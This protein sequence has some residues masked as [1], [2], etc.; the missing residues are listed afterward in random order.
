[1]SIPGSEDDNATDRDVG[2]EAR[3]RGEWGR[4]DGRGGVGNGKRR[5]VGVELD[6]IPLCSVCSVEK[7]GENPGQV[8]ERGLEV[9]TSLDGGLSRDR[10]DILFDEREGEI[11]LSPKASTRNPRRLRGVTGIEQEL[12]RYINAS[13]GRYVSTN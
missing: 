5:G 1:M 6:T 4:W 12:K 13:S 10:L 9:V 2:L 7:E 8:L 3:R 11:T